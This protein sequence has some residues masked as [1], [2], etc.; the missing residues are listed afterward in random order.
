MRESDQHWLPDL[1]VAVIRS[2]WANYVPFVASPS[3]PSPSVARVADEPSAAAWVPSPAYRAAAAAFNPLGHA[4]T[5][6]LAV[7][8]NANGFSVGFQHDQSHSRHESVDAEGDNRRQRASR[9]Y[10]SPVPASPAL[11][12]ATPLVN[13]GAFATIAGATTSKAN[14]RA[15]SWSGPNGRRLD[16]DVCICNTCAWPG[17]PVKAGLPPTPL[18]G[19]CKDAAT[20][21][22]PHPPP[23]AFAR[24]TP[25]PTNFSANPSDHVGDRTTR[26]RRSIPSPAPS[27]D[28]TPSALSSV[29]CSAAASTSPLPLAFQSPD[30]PVST[31]PV[32][33]NNPLG[34]RRLADYVRLLV[35]CEAMSMQTVLYALI[36]IR[37]LRQTNSCEPIREGSELQL[38]STAL[39]LAQKLLDDDRTDNAAWIPFCGLKLEDINAMEKEFLT[40]VKWDLVVTRDEYNRFVAYISSEASALVQ[41][42]CTPRPPSPTYRKHVRALPNIS[43]AVPSPNLPPRRMSTSSH[44]FRTRTSSAGSGSTT[45][46]PNIAASIARGLSRYIPVF[47]RSTSASGHGLEAAG[48][49]ASLADV[50]RLL[51]PSESTSP[52]ESPSEWGGAGGSSDR[53]E[54][55]FNSRFVDEALQAHTMASKPIAERTWLGEG[56]YEPAIIGRSAVRPKRP[57]LTPT[58]TGASIV[59]AQWNPAAPASSY[60]LSCIVARQNVH[61]EYPQRGE[62][63]YKHGP[64]HRRH[65]SDRTHSPAG[66]TAGQRIHR[67]SVAPADPKG[68]HLHPPAPCHRSGEIRPPA[69]PAVSSRPSTAGSVRR[70]AE[71]A[72][73]ERRKLGHPKTQHFVAPNH[74][75][76]HDLAY[77][78]SNVCFASPAFG[79]IKRVQAEFDVLTA[80][81]DRLFRENQYRPAP[82]RPP[83]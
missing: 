44:S 29:Y 74:C 28:S 69:V 31:N 27:T 6:G 71:V 79:G 24:R 63:K 45:P 30:L 8:D 70:A 16:E 62:P 61:Y 4:G 15:I 81:L 78:N 68:T 58:P 52:L 67:Q 3:Y 72:I 9:R 34:R 38:F 54:F 11:P 80:E 43:A 32:S 33:L 2:T 51:S 76:Q 26:A 56:S 36:L 13:I 49:T 40:K 19:W 10:P 23:P 37:R 60:E 66:F 82:I 53:S 41:A 77:P 65:S 75:Y 83:L 48:R 50:P 42:S 59:S 21:V 18:C 17:V 1:V 22:W 73:A 57:S 7:F 39:L 64:Q 35:A 12:A 5:L 25:T 14:P 55:A 20:A 46:S 47:S